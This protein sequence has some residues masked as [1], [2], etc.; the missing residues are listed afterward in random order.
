VVDDDH[1]AD[2]RDGCVRDVHESRRV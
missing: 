1:R 2:D